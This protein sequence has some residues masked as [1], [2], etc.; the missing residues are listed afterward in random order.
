MM[1]V[2]IANCKPINNKQMILFLVQIKL[3]KMKS[4]G[5]RNQHFNLKMVLNILAIGK[6]NIAMDM[7]CKNG[8]TN[9]NMMEIGTT[10]KKTDK[11]HLTT[12]M[13]MFIMVVGQWT[14]Q[15]GMEY[16]RP[17]QDIDMKEYGRII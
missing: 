13:G 5:T 12:Q 7:V 1:I 8:Q 16:I 6:G 2:K 9:Q 15:M 10:I 4:N 17:L 3:N 14:W 11:E